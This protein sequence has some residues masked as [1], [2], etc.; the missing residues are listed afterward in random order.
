MHQDDMHTNKCLWTLYYE[1]SKSPTC[2][3][4]THIYIFRP[5][6]FPCWGRCY[7]KDMLQRLQK[8]THKYSFKMYVLKRVCVTVW[9]AE[10]MICAHLKSDHSTVLHCTVR[11]NT[12]QY[13]TVQYYTL[14]YSAVQYNTVPYCTVRMW[15]VWHEQLCLGGGAEYSD[16]CVT[17]QTDSC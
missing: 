5:L 17:R 6:L 10:K 3:A 7:T 14:Q 13:S 8:P 1:R 9:N 16:V 15:E 12:V 2:V 4:F 11:Y